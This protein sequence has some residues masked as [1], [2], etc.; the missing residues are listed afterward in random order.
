MDRGAW[1]AT[2][3]GVTQ[4]DMTKHTHADVSKQDFADLVCRQRR[5]T[6]RGSMRNPLES[7]RTPTKQTG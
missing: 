5:S 2:V 1:K 7:L 3:H 6:Y 4:L